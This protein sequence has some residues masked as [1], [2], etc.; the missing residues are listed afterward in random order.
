M[1]A[2]LCEETLNCALETQTWCMCPVLIKRLLRSTECT[3]IWMGPSV[4]LRHRPRGKENRKKDGWRHW[5]EVDVGEK[6]TGDTLSYVIKSLGSW[7]VSLVAEI[8]CSCRGSRFV[9]NT[10]MMTLKLQFQR[11]WHP[12]LISDGTGHICYSHTCTHAKHSYT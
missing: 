11:I 10:N 4:C 6:A 1:P 3:A 8:F 9:P 2:Q 7:T 5:K 12:L